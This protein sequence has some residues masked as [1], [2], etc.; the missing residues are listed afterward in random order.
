MYNCISL[1]HMSNQHN[2]VNQYCKSLSVKKFFKELCYNCLRFPYSD[3]YLTIND[4]TQNLA[5]SQHLQ[6]CLPGLQLHDPQVR[7]PEVLPALLPMA[8]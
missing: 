4:Q 3:A 1:R 5:P 7:S 8:S 6:P 2:T